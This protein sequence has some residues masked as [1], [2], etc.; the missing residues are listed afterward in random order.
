[1]LSVL[2]LNV[3]TLFYTHSGRFC[4][5]EAM[6]SERKNHEKEPEKFRFITKIGWK[7]HNKPTVIKVINRYL[8]KYDLQ[9]TTLTF[10]L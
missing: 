5:D 8:V 4:R 9:D 2:K 6:V 1:M 7:L 10:Y 3:A